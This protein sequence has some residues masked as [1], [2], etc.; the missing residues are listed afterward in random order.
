M[1]DSLLCALTVCFA[2]L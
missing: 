1:L 2:I